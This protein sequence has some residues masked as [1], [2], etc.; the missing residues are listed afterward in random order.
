MILNFY[1]SRLVICILFVF[2]FGCTDYYECRCE[3]KKTN[4][5]GQEVRGW[6]NFTIVATRRNARQYC[7]EYSQ[8]DWN[9]WQCELVE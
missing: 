6:H 4:N 9:S 7:K 8:P 2:S 5:E 3:Y 1:A